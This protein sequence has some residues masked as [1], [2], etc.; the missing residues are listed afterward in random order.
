MRHFLRQLLLFVTMQ[1]GVLGW[2]VYQAQTDSSEYLASIEDKHRLLAATPAPRLIVAGG[3]NVAFGIDSSELS[4]QVPYHPVNMGLHAGLGVPFMLNELRDAA[5]TEHDVVVLSFEY[6]HF[7][8]RKTPGT[9]LLEILVSRPCSVSYIDPGELGWCLDNGL[10][11]FSRVTRKAVGHTLGQSPDH[12]APYMRPSFNEYCDVID[13]RE[14]PP[15]RPLIA[16]AW[17]NFSVAGIDETIDRL[18][19]FHAHC[20]QRGTTVLYSFPPIERAYARA[21]WAEI[22]RVARRL[23]QRLTVPLLDEPPAMLFDESFFFDSVYHL[24]A[25]GTALRTHLLAGKLQQVTGIQTP[26]SNA[27]GSHPAT[28]A[29]AS[30]TSALANSARR[31]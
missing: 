17:P 7:A 28:N 9:E 18:N 4:H 13:H 16:S 6:E 3:S 24:N 20:R 2:C 19:D 1:T 25:A 26:T 12:T 22:E 11:W 5:L 21:N 15:R 27:A 8:D 14:L 31:K 10:H 29:G 30:Q 23:R